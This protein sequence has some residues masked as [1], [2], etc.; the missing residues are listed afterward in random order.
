MSFARNATTGSFWS[1]LCVSK[2][3]KENFSISKW[4]P[5][6]AGCVI[7]PKIQNDLLKIEQNGVLIRRLA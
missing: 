6:V 4:L 3:S 7:V 2:R 5:T 1:V